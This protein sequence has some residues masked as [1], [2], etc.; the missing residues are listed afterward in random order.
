MAVTLSQKKG[1]TLVELIVVMGILVVV[2]TLMFANNSRFGGVVFLE[3]LAYDVALSLRKAQIY[4][5]AVRRFGSGEF[6]V[7][8]GLH[9][10]MSDPTRYV[11]FAD[12]VTAN[13][14]FDCPTPPGTCESLETSEMQQGYHLKDICVTQ[15]GG[16]EDCSIE[17]LDITFKRPEP[18]AY[19]RADDD[20]LPLYEKAEIIL[21][22]PRL[23]EISVVVEVT[24]QIAVE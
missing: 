18:D 20:A 9:F 1:F 21:E 14:T 22:S 12:G 17:T 7:A 15:A 23:D 13:G 6:D 5:I 8:Y 16:G 24:G 3:N 4:G 19:I 11:L 2:S 10:A